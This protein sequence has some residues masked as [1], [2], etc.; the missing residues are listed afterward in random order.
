MHVFTVDGVLVLGRDPA[1]GGLRNAHRCGEGGRQLAAAPALPLVL[2]S[3]AQLARLLAPYADDPRGERAVG[4]R[5]ARTRLAEGHRAVLIEE[6]GRAGALG[7]VA[8]ERHALGDL[9]AP[10]VA[11]GGRRVRPRPRGDVAQR[12]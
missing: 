2:A 4:V 10:E 5:E 3:E 9:G 12:V 1:D 11:G 8:R 7:I 6:R